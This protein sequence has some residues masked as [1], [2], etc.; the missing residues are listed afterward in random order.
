MNT[1]PIIAITVATL[2]VIL[3]AVMFVVY[4]RKGEMPETNY[5]LFFILGIVWL[6]IGIA[7]QNPGLWGMGA[8]FLIV[9]LTNR[10]KWQ[11]NKL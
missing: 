6:P 8:V 10:D 11:D 9:G 1:Y 7:T 5:R 4:R 3:L 2:L